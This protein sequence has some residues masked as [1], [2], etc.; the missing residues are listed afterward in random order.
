MIITDCA[1]Q[2]FLNFISLLAVHPR[3]SA[4]PPEPALAAAGQACIAI[5]ASTWRDQVAHRWH[6]LLLEP[7]PLPLI[8]SHL[9][10]QVISRSRRPPSSPRLR[11]SHRGP[12]LDRAQPA[13]P[14]SRY[15]GVCVGGAAACSSDEPEN[16][17]DG[18]LRAARSVRPTG[19]TERAPLDWLPASRL[20]VPTPTFVLSTATW[21]S[22]LFVCPSSPPE[23][24]EPRHAIGLS[25]HRELAEPYFGPTPAAP[26]RDSELFYHP[27]FPFHLCLPTAHF[28]PIHHQAIAGGARL[29][30]VQPFTRP[31]V[32]LLAPVADSRLQ[33]ANLVTTPG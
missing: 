16:S 13:C 5:R 14:P 33:L 3:W 23:V 20:L 27:N 10:A 4:N 24:F 26:S 11:S 17:N 8:A 21:S 6:G 18:Q 1:G 25:S 7:S 15:G 28:I 30:P 31:G 29:S 19:P 32:F 2:K 9:S 12:V 22:V